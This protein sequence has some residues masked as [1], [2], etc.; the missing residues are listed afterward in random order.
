MT[1]KSNNHYQ[2]TV[3]LCDTVKPD[4]FSSEDLRWIIQLQNEEK[5]SVANQLRDSVG[6]VL[7]CCKLLLETKQPDNEQR[8][9]ELVNKHLQ[10][11]IGEI[12]HL[13]Y[14]LTDSFK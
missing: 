6:Q 7:T 1:F 4:L 9:L 12:M 5:Q 11:T 13:S 14:K 3:L 2:E 10:K 8:V